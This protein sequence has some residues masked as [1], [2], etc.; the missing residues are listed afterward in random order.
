MT[1]RIAEAHKALKKQMEEDRQRLVADAKRNGVGIVH[2]FN[3]KNPKGGM[4]IAFRKTMPNQQS[5]NMVD[6]AIATCSS[7]DTFDRKIGTQI[8]LAKWFNTETISMPLSSGR[9]EEDLNGRVKYIFTEMW[10]SLK[11]F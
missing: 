10:E 11:D 1:N 3:P 5:T 9:P 6:V 8:A 7:A 4:T 2:A